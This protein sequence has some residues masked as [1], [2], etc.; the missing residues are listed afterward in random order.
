MDEETKQE[1][2]IVLQLLKKTCNRNGV[3]VGFYTKTK[4]LVFFDEEKFIEEGEISGIKITLGNL[5][6]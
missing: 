2:E 5:V 1:L 6:K 4:E 3:A